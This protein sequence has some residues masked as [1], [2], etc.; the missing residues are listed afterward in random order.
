MDAVLPT[1]C[2]GVCLLS[3]TLLVLLK[4]DVYDT[5]LLPAL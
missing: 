5:V 4:L 2:A 3:E 1:V